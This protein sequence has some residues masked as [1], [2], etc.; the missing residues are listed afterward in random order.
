MYLPKFTKAGA[1]V[2]ALSVDTPWELKKLAKRLE[3][4]FPVYRVPLQIVR[5]LHLQEGSRTHA[6]PATFI[7][8]SKGRV[9]YQ[10]IGKSVPDRPKESVLLQT[11]KEM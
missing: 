5:Q 7:V 10:H 6:R 11:L 2:V 4:T 1:T 9:V 3:L 8:N